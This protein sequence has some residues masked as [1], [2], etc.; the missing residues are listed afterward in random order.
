MVQTRNVVIKR[1]F[2]PSLGIRTSFL[3][4]MNSE[5]SPRVN[6][7]LDLRANP[8]LHSTTV[9]ASCYRDPSFTLGAEMWLDA[10]FSACPG[11][12]DA[13]WTP[14]TNEAL[15]RFTGKVR[16]HNAS[17][18]VTLGSW[19][20]SRNMIV[21]RTQKIAKIFTK[22]EHNL[23][24]DYDRMSP[25][26]RAARRRALSRDRA[27]D[28][29]EG[30][31]GWLPLVTDISDALGALGQSPH[32]QWIR[33]RSKGEHRLSSL[34]APS[35][36]EYGKAVAEEGNLSVVVSARCVFDSPNTFLANR[37]GLLAL[38]GVAWDL[39]PWSFVVNMFTNM[40][41][42]VNSVTDF[43]GVTVSNVSLTKSAV[44]TQR[45][46]LWASKLGNQRGSFGSEQVLKHSL[47]KYR[48]VRPNV[49]KPSFQLKVPELNLELA[50]IAIS[51]I[52]QKM[53]RINRLVGDNL[54]FLN[55][56]LS[57]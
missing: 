57:K 1:D 19:R 47:Y 31:F 41:Q 49:P 16:K 39:I 37:L 9:I 30:E 43:V 6:G 53:S 42:L 29:L 50:L 23:M 55:P 18:G 10:Q 4:L 20:E 14:L 15:A 17:L 56:V 44:V 26:Q 22:V 12:T 46:N 3:D 8:H 54:P 52:L 21:D 33:S 40:G 35:N 32:N 25:K 2:G 7:K 24:K 36:A 28:F 27:S 38:P 45:S 13:V 51:L 34:Y 48:E 11:Q 5:K